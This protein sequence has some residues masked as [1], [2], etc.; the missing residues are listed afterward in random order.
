L[1][2][3]FLFEP[4]NIRNGDSIGKLGDWGGLEGLQGLL[5]TNYDVVLI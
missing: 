1:K 2:D 3:S 4:D 5:K